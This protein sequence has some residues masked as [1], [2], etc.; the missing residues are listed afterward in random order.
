MLGSRPSAISQTRRCSESGVPSGIRT[1]V[2]AVKGR[3]PWP[4][5]DRDIVANTGS[6][7]ATAPVETASDSTGRTGDYRYSTTT[8]DSICMVRS[9]EIESRQLVPE[10]SVQPS[11]SDLIILKYLRHTKW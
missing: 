8:G 5:D 1:R 6:I 2:I 9:R 7:I 3:C 11:H 10:T 4:L